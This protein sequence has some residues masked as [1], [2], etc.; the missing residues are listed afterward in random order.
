MQSVPQVEMLAH[1]TV[2]E[3]W[4]QHMDKDPVGNHREESKAGNRSKA[5]SLGYVVKSSRIQEKRGRVPGQ[6]SFQLSAEKYTNKQLSS[7]ICNQG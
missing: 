4:A 6:P 2:R 5:V 3:P 1:C 7:V